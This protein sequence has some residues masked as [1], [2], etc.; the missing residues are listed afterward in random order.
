MRP[1]PATIR[2]MTTFLLKTEPGAYSYDDLERDGSTVWEGVTN[3]AAL[4]R[5][6]TARKGDEALIYHTGDE[7][8]I[9][10]LATITSDARSPKG[11]PKLAVFDL[12]AKKRAR[13]PV[14]LGAIK[15]DPRFTDFDLVRQGRL[16]VMIVP[17]EIDTALRA[18]AGL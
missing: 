1:R 14:T 8:T 3:N 2:S 4:L 9:V 15:A 13:T 11:E 10:G 6:R 7:R 18:M 5:M 16:S 12:R 17:P